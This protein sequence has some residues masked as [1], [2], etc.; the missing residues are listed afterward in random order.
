V[1]VFEQLQ[2]LGSAGKGVS[3]HLKIM[4]LY[5][6]TP[7]FILQGLVFFLQTGSN[8]VEAF[9]HFA[10]LVILLLYSGSLRLPALLLGLLRPQLDCCVF[11]LN[12]GQLQLGLR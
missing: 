1:V 4:Q 5:L 6:V 9:L 3:L 7:D 10:E 12:H 2:L 8:S 11:L